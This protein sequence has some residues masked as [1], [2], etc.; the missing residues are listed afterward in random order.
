M[1]INR[2]FFV[3]LIAQGKQKSILIARIVATEL[4]NEKNMCFAV[5]LKNSS[6]K[7]CHKE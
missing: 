3:C 2:F 6:I 1:T 7:T 4:Q 5:H